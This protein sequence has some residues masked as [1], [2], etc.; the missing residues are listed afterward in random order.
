MALLL[1]V[2]VILM[3]LLVGFE[4]VLTGVSQLVDKPI[5]TSGIVGR[6]KIWREFWPRILEYPV[7]GNGFGDYALTLDTGPA[8]PHSL[9]IYLLYRS[10]M[11][12]TGL[13]VLAMIAVYGTLTRRVRS[14][15]SSSRGLYI[16]VLAATSIQLIRETVEISILGNN[17]SVT[18]LFW[19]TILL[20]FSVAE[21][22]GPV[23]SAVDA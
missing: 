10:G 23:T 21:E 4:P 18:L 2:S 8:H 7:F 12:G 3:T 20:A 15:D 11:A 14:S 13:F 16:A 9:Y 1:T 19:E 22:R 6:T 17:A 5:E